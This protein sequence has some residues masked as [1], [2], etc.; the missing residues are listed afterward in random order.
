MECFERALESGNGTRAAMDDGFLLA[1]FDGTGRAIRSALALRRLARELQLPCSIGVNVGECLHSGISVIGAPVSV[2]RAA[3]EAAGTGEI[4]ATRIVRDL[5]TGF[6]FGTER[7]V[8]LAGRSRS[9]WT[10][11]E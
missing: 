10:V 4:A 3:A 2:V 5:V 9:L 1:A 11:D 8:P 6:R 7:S